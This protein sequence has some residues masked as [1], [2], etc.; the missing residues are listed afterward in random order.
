MWRTST[1]RGQKGEKPAVQTG[2]PVRKAGPG[3]QVKR[4]SERGGRD[5]LCSAKLNKMG[6]EAEPPDLRRQRL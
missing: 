1:L 6:T 2:E 3:S 5:K 4:V